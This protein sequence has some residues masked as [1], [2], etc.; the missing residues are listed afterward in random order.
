VRIAVIGAGAMGGIFGATLAEGGSDVSLIDVS[1]DVVD[2]IRASGIIVRRGGE[3]RSIAVR[4]TTDPQ[5]VGE[6]DLVLFFVKCYHTESA[7]QMVRPLVGSRTLVATLQNGWGNGDVLARY[8]DRDRMIIGI[9]YHSGTNAGPG[10]VLHTN[11]TDAPTL[12]GPYEGH[13]TGN[14][15]RLAEAVTAGGLRA[16][17]TPT[18][19]S[20]IWKKLVLNSATLP[21]SALTRLTAGALGADERMTEVVNWLARETVAVGVAQGLEVDESER[22]E[23]IHTTLIGAGD[24]KASMLQDVERGRRT[25]IDVINGAVERAAETAGVDVP[26]NRAMLALVKAYE[27]ANGLA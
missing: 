11:T 5:E 7:A 24:G 15:E 21:T 23:A 9:T 10:I 18:I 26:L 2:R 1:E 12:L 17:A 4:A 25:E 16:E 13:D 3:E 27:A 6:V 19:R 22:I 14:A 20:E 8:F